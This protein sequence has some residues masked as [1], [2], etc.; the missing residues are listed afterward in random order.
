MTK[1]EYINEMPYIYDPK[2]SGSHYLIE[3]A[4]GYCNRGNFCESA[5]KYHRGLPYLVNPTTEA[6]EGYDIP[7]EK[8]EVK[9]AEAGL[10][11]H[12]G[13]RD[14]S[15]SQQ[16]RY[17]FQ[18]KPSDAKWIWVNF[19]AKT[20]VITEWQMNKSEFG[21][22]L[23]VALRRKQHTQ[24]NKKSI[25]IRFKAHSRKLEKWLDARCI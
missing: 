17:Y 15:V 9:S 3:G 2:H 20:G 23:H 12:I 1:I 6:L 21:A 5:I 19:N 18:H 22:F 24:S 14:F 10:G 13:E 11:R 25:S 7:E 8:A 16:I 4:S